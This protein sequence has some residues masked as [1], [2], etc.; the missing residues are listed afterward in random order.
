MKNIVLIGMPGSGKST[1]G[2]ALAAAAGM[3]FLDTDDS[4]QAFTGEPL[5]V[6]LNREGKEPF[7]VIENQV[8]AGV[9]V[10]NTVI[11]TGG[12]VVYGK[13]AMENL[14]NNGVFVYLQYDFPTLDK[15]LTNLDTRG[16]AFGP[17]ETIYDLFLERVPIYE[18]VTDVTIS[19]EGKTLEDIVREILTA[20]K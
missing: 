15:R 11:A 7:L 8:C 12:S 1:V 10:E 13:E 17:G 19:C 5:Q 6:T 18:Q 4:I 20:V 14:R 16:V 2:K 9:H 3:E